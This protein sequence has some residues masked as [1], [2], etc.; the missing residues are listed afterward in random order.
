LKIL[1]V[2]QG[3]DRGGAERQL[4]ALATGL[5]Q[6]GDQSA[7]AVLRGGGAFDAALGTS[8]V[9]LHVVGGR[10]AVDLVP[11]VIRLI[12]LLRAERPDVVHG[13]LAVGNLLS[14][15][16][17]VASPRSRVVWGVRHAELDLERF[18][19]KVRV[20]EWLAS[21]T[22]RLAHLVIANSD[23]GARYHVDLGY[24]AAKIVTVHNGIDTQHFRPADDEARAAVR[25][26]WG[27]PVDAVVIGMVARSDTTKDH[28]SFVRAAVGVTGSRPAHAVCVGAI[29][30]PVRSRLLALARSLDAT[31]RVHLVGP[32]E[33][34]A[35]AC[36]GFDIACLA[37]RTEGFPNV[38][39]EGM[40]CGVPCVVTAVGDAPAIVGDLGEI[41]ELTPDALCAAME[42][43]LGRLDVDPTL[44]RRA[45]ERVV[46]RFGLTRL[47][48]ET[49]ARLIG[50][51]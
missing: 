22:A 29:A 2:I 9:P 27:V 7:V 14:L 40:A 34:V 18:G 1:F 30:E 3:L 50:I 17:R 11:A 12:R 13:Y 19:I 37:S 8:D 16:A 28:E 51:L 20:S 10:R 15:V 24:P 48:D 25:A 36:S 38:V 4:V 41:V 31:D 43:L 35:A 47:I 42:R 6:R 5:A 49:S 23:A 45:R 21:R 26:A 44:R 32:A 46:Q 39:A 33:D